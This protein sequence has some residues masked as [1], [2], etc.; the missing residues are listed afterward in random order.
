MKRSERQQGQDLDMCVSVHK[1]NCKI[2][3]AG[4]KRK[5]NVRTRKGEEKMCVRECVCE[6]G[7]QREGERNAVLGD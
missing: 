1:G 6:R 3:R 7:L 4:I 2:M 5:S